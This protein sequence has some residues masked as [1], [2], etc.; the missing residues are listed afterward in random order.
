MLRE[1]E[2]HKEQTDKGQPVRVSEAMNGATTQQDENEQETM[3]VIENA[4]EYQTRQTN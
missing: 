4:L 3:R 2:G 1:G